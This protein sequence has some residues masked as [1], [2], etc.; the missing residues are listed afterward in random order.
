MTILG[1]GIAC[2]IPKAKNT[3]SQYVILSALTLQQWLELR[4]SI[5]RYTNILRLV[6]PYFDKC[7]QILIHAYALFTHFN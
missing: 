2:W 3:H 4:A 6:F 5:L 1:K 7:W